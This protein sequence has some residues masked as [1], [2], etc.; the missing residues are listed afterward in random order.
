M[1]LDFMST[2]YVTLSIQNRYLA[3]TLTLTLG[4]EQEQLLQEQLLQQQPQRQQ[5]MMA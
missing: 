1:L 3:L 5:L 2:M 4:Q